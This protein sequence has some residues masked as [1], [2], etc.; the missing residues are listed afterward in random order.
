MACLCKHEY[1]RVKILRESKMIADQPDLILTAT[2]D[3]LD[4]VTKQMTDRGEI[5]EGHLQLEM[6]IQ[7][8]LLCVAVQ[9]DTREVQIQ[10]STAMT[11][12]RKEG[13]M[14]EMRAIRL[15]MVVAVVAEWRVKRRDLEEEDS[16][17]AR[18]RKDQGA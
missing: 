2:I 17:P 9:E 7:V 5:Q 4:Q 10:M 11:D 18:G 15:R 6:I 12:R 3:H 1:L 16:I 14:V 8:H 13:N